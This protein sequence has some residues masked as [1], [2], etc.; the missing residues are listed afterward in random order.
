VA[1]TETVVVERVGQVAT[2][3]M[4]RGRA[5]AGA[6]GQ[7]EAGSPGVAGSPGAAGRGNVHWELATVFS[8]LREDNGVRVVVL[9]GSDGE[10][11]VPAQREDYESGPWQERAVDAAER[12]LTFTGLIRC[13]ELMAE[14]EK[15]IVGRING[16]AVGF[17]QSLAFACDL[18]IA[19]EDARFMD[20]HMGGAALDGDRPFRGHGFSVVPGD[21]GAAL[22]PLYLTPPR[23]KE[24]L[25]LCRPYTA[26]ELAD[27]GVINR[28][29]PAERLDEEVDSVVRQLLERGAYALAWTKRVVN[30]PL[31]AQLNRTLDAAAAYEMVGFWQLSKSGWEN[32]SRLVP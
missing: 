3:T 29:V 25:M 2:V 17:G 7:A 10:F 11:K 24:Y 14:I 20:H 12:W 32:P 15:P 4:L 5:A 27:M 26:R 9:T 18:I 1:E 28:A 8:E 21:G 16:D 22:L 19:R 13:H 6:G 30:L 31:R 23:A